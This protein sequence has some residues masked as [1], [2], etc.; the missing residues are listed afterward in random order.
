[1]NS[2]FGPAGQNLPGQA[3][4]GTDRNGLRESFER[5]HQTKQL[6][7]QAAMNSHPQ[8]AMT[9]ADPN[10]SEAFQIPLSQLVT[11][12]RLKY[13]DQWVDGATPKKKLG[14]DFYHDAFQRLI[15]T[16][17]FERFEGWYRLKEDV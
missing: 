5:Y 2:I 16:D 6:A 8:Q 17:L 12:W 9:R 7:E 13:G 4:W 11:M 3:L 14:E 10:S 15:A 1:M